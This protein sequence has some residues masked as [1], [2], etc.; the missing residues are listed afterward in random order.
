MLYEVI[1]QAASQSPKP[2]QPQ[3][4]ILVPFTES[5]A[6]WQVFTPTYP[7]LG[8]QNSPEPW[9]RSTATFF[10]AEASTPMIF[11]TSAAQEA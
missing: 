6:A 10:S 5:L 11:P 3:S 8:L 4:H 9:Q 1:T 2:M 7:A